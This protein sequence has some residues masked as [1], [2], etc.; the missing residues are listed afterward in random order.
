M[1]APGTAH[2]GGLAGKLAGGGGGDA[3]VGS[4]GDGAAAPTASASV[5]GHRRN[6]SGGIIGSLGSHRRSSSNGSSV[7]STA[8]SIVSSTSNG[9]TV[10]SSTKARSSVQSSS[11]PISC[12][13]RRR[14]RRSR[15]HLLRPLPSLP[16]RTQTAAQSTK[17]AI[18]PARRHVALLLP[19][20]AEVRVPPSRRQ[21]AKGRRRQLVGG[22]VNPRRSRCFSIVGTPRYVAPEVLR[23]TGH[24]TP[25]DW[26]A[27]GVIA[28]ELLTG[29]S[30]SKVRR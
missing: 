30:H 2:A 23:A 24:S 25:V 26:W 28:F 18:F 3:T 17:R 20:R 13:C 29:S 8:D 11:L 9:A 6:G 12:W 14:N 1:H 16:R 19:P 22:D 15:Y 21:G 5:K 10:T 4:A 27:L 7:L